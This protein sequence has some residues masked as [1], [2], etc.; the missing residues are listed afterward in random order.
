MA[1][2]KPSKIPKVTFKND[3]PITGLA[4]IGHTKGAQIKVGGQKIGVITGTSFMAGY[5]RHR[6]RLMVLSEENSCGWAWVQLKYEGD[7]LA[8]VKQWIK[9]H[10]DEIYKRY[11]FRCTEP[12]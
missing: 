9:D 4:A 6:I 10:W 1:E 7:S 8:E 2:Q 11:D 3:P 12:D 5:A